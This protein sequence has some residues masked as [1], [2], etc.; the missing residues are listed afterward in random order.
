MCKAPISLSIRLASC[1][2]LGQTQHVKTMEATS[3]NRT[4][5]PPGGRASERREQ[6]RSVERR[7]AILDASLAEFAEHGFDAAST[8]NIARRAGIHNTLLTYHFRTKEALWR[9]TAEHFFLEISEK[10]AT[11]SAA[12][13]SLSPI[14]KLREEFR[15]F[16]N[17]VVENPSFHQFMIREGQPGNPRLP[18]LTQTFVVPIMSR[19]FPLIEAAQVSGDLPLARPILMHYFLVSILTVLS[20]HSAEIQYH[21]GIAPLSSSMTEDY[22]AV[23]D[24]L[25]FRRGHNLPDKQGN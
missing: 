4:A 3:G 24:R 1:R 16:F 14:E 22:W 20:A 7:I 17:F 11:T 12:D 15:S 10:L 2:G 9:A 25:V 13:P 18:W 19:T 8:R 6:Q 23:V 21:S 5:S